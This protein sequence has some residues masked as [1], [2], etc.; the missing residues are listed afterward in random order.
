MANSKLSRE[1]LYKLVWSEPT[2]IIAKRVGVSD[3]AVAKACK[4]MRIPKPGRGYWQQR[5][6][7]RVPRRRRLPQLSPGEEKRLGSVEFGQG[8]AVREPEREDGPVGEQT[9][10]EA[11]P[12][13]RIRVAK[14]LRNPHELIQRTRDNMKARG[15]YVP[16]EVGRIPSLDIRVYGPTW[17]RALRIMNTL[18]KALET[19][20]YKVET[21][22]GYK[23]TTYAIV[24]KERVEFRLRELQKV[25]MRPRHFSVLGR[26]QYQALEPTGRL[27]L[28]ID[29]YAT[30]IR[31]TWSDGKKQ[32]VED[33][34]NAFVV[35]LVAVA[36]VKKE[37]TLRLERERAER[38]RARQEQIEIERRR[39]AEAMRGR[40]LEAEAAAWNRACS[41]RAYIEGV[42]Q[43][44]V[45]AGREHSPELVEWLAW[46]EEYA[47]SLDPLAQRLA[48]T[49]RRGA[50]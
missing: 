14:Q 48:A 17:S 3:V 29:E 15:R 49:A 35:S 18:I 27:S 11:D 31:K 28:V 46:G 43:S 19:R 5:V 10:Y 13:N 30:G 21:G 1:E 42:Q 44:A 23:T 7:G 38:E 47:Q 32:Q 26:D 34:L 2:Q 37:R 39:E 22:R 12:K 40:Q 8:A 6:A 9:R 36:E 4:R 45:E 16:D 50:S 20:G 41:V 33:C 25:V 24:G